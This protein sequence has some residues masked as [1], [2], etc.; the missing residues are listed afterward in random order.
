MGDDE[1][2]HPHT[3]IR[4]LISLH[5]SSIIFSDIPDGIPSHETFGVV[6]S[7]LDPE[8]FQAT[9]LRACRRVCLSPFRST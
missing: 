4:Q 1:N 7:R 6:L 5:W 9:G 8:Q 3:R 2:I